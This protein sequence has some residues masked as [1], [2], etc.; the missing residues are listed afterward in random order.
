M[1]ILWNVWNGRLR[2][3]ADRR[4]V[5]FTL[6]LIVI[7]LPFARG[8]K[9]IELEDF[10]EINIFVSSNNVGKTSVLVTMGLSGLF[11]DAQLLIQTL[12]LRYQQIS[13]D[14][15]KDMFGD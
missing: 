13:I 3:S 5:S 6:F 10:S 15:M 14:L 9:Q 2:N 4:N 12:I 11:D 1:G 7:V 8:L